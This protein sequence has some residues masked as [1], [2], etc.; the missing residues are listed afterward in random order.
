MRDGGRAGS[1]RRAVLDDRPHP[2]RDRDRQGGARADGPRVQPA[3]QRAVRPGEPRR[4]PRGAHRERAVRPREGRVHRRDPAAAGALRAGRR[5]HAS[6]STRSGTRR[7]RCRCGSSASSRSASSSASAAPN[8]SQ[9]DVRVVAAT[10]RNLEEMVARGTFRADLYY[11]LAVFPVELPP[12]RER[13]EDVRPLASLLPRAPA[14]AMHRRPPRVSEDVVARAR[15]AR[16]ARNVRE[17]ENFLQRALILSPGPELVAARA[18]RRRLA[19]PRRGRA[20]RRRAGAVR[21]RGARPHRARPHPRGRA[22]LRAGRR[23]GAPRAAAHD[24]PGQDEEVRR[25][26]PDARQADRSPGQCARLAG[27]SDLSSPAVAAP[28]PAPGTMRAPLATGAPACA[29]SRPSPSRSPCAGCVSTRPTRRRSPR[30]TSSA[31]TGRTRPRHRAKLE[32]QLREQQKALQAQLDTLGRRR[33]L[34]EGED[35]LRRGHALAEGVASSAPPA[36]GCV[37]LQALIDE[38]SKSKKK[39]EVGQGR[40]REEER[41]VRAA[42]RRALRGEI[43]SGPASS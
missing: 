16:L 35:P 33:E 18:P 42:R 9:V 23:G 14:A 41:R 19:A 30:R 15:G 8:R 21:R 31:R 5:R 32:V 2:R 1:A 36:S 43:E 38:L 28:R 26:P 25:R 40:A 27:L 4:D 3:L 6:S 10:N 34:A 29:A 22:G 7:P 17:L 12:L 24:A 37:E 20:R 13:R 39:L 11:R